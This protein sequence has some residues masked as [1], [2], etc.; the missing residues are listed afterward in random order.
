MQY[1]LFLLCVL[2]WLFCGWYVVDWGGLSLLA[3]LD[4][5]VLVAEGCVAR[6][7]CRVPVGVVFVC[8]FVVL[9]GGLLFESH[10][11][12]GFEG[13]GE[14]LLV[15]FFGGPAG[16]AAE[17]PA[18]PAGWECCEGDGVAGEVAG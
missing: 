12:F 10:V 7:D 9:C 14:G 4:G 1:L 5:G 17:F 18:L 15:P 8:W 11:G 2:A 13:V 6:A 3:R 16:V